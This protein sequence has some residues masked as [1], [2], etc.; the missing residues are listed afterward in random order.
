MMRVLRRALAQTQKELFQFRRDPLT[1]MLAFVL[2]F[3][4]MLMYGFATK[5]EAKD[6]PVAIANYDSGKFSRDYIDCIFASGQF[7]PI[8]WSGKHVL[9]PLDDGEAK[10]TIVIPPEFSRK[11]KQRQ[12]AEVQVL[13]DGT[14]VNNARIIKNG[15]LALTE[16]Y[17]AQEGLPQKRSLVT[18]RIRLWFNPGRK[19][20]LHIVPGAI[21]LV[22]WIFPALLAAFAMV[23]EKEQ[24][25]ILQLYASS[26]T[27][28]ELILGK[29][30]AYFCIGMAVSAIVILESFIVFQVPFVGNPLAFFICTVLYVASGVVFGT[31]A[32]TRA[33]NQMAAVQICAMVGFLGSMLLS[34]FIYPIRNITYPISLISNVVAARYYIE[35]ARDAFVRGGSWTAHWYAPV[36]LAGITLFFLAL[37]VAGM[38]KMQLSK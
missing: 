15:L 13:I 36:M 34:G 17:L 10:A 8:T 27:A 25:T 12:R 35:A 33:N 20:T 3:V 21:A 4:A 28:F 5:L 2:P 31:W 29:A 38:R 11:L 7:I 6:I 23:R 32:G 22:T 24:G 18:P 37:G 16:S 14:D 1:V 19:E 9:D 30:I 26:I